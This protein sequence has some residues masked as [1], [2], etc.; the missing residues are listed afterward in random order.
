MTADY[1]YDQIE[2]LR[3]K[4][5]LVTGAGGFLGNALLRRLVS[6][7]LAVKGTV[8]F[9]NELTR[10]SSKGLD[11]EILDLASDEPW[12]EI[13]KGYD[14][15]FHLAAMFQ[16]YNKSAEMY[17]K[18]NH[19]SVVK[20][21]QTANRVGVSRFVH[22]S[23]VGVHGDVKEIPATEETPYN[24]MDIYHTTKLAGELSLLE[25]AGTLSEGGMT[26]TVNRPSMV[27]GPGD[28]RMRKLFTTINKKRFF[29]I[30]KGDVLAHLCYVDDQIDSFILS[31]VASRDKVHL[32]S[33]NI[34][35]AEPITL[36]DLA[37]CIANNVAAS[38][39]IIHI[40][41]APVWIAALVCELICKPF[42]ISPPLFRRRVGFF[43]HNRAFNIEKA[44]TCL[45]YKPRFTEQTGIPATIDYYRAKGYL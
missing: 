2:P 45:G 9:S 26:V 33:F 21:A 20:L 36:N 43:T 40:P 34:S 4:K 8:L 38:I 1:V 13:L 31:S 42:G 30:G 22:C 6:Y 15:V 39:P 11:I 5:I 35:S 41:V 29:M 23:T 18:V 44:R 10:L 7:N 32:E 28:D 27:Y 3:G 14:V 37:K 16:E 25:Y 19:H 24:P 12:D 17:E